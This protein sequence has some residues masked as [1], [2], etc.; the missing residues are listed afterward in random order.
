MKS[1]I[2]YVEA[3]KF[4]RD[5]RDTVND[6]VEAYNRTEEIQVAPDL[7]TAGKIEESDLKKVYIV[8][9]NAGGAGGAGGTPYFPYI[10]NIGGT[11]KVGIYI[12]STSYLNTNSKTA[13]QTTPKGLLTKLNPANDDTGWLTTSTTDQAYIEYKFDTANWPN[14]VMNGCNIKTVASG[15]TFL[16]GNE[17]EYLDLSGTGAGPFVQSYARVPIVNMG[18]DP[19][20]NPFAQW[21]LLNRNPVL[22]NFIQTAN[23]STGANPRNI[24]CLYPAL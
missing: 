23:D 10:R 2:E 13:N 9:L 5:L 1:P 21:I 19:N 18:S 6:L 20:G 24:R 17:L 11:Y 14:L 3:N 15:G 12:Y 7:A 22:L 4:P 8:P 16:T